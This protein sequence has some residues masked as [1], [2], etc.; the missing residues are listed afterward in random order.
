MLEWII[1]LL[2]SYLEG[3][4]SYLLIPVVCLAF[5]GTVPC[6]VR[7]IFSYFRG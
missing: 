2:S 4:G 3:L 6:I 5:I 1:P 7:S